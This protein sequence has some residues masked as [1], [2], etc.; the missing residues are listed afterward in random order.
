MKK[1]QLLLLF[2]FFFCTIFGQNTQTPRVL[3]LIPDNCYQLQLI[4][5][6]ELSNDLDLAALDNDKILNPLYKEKKIIKNFVRSWIQM[7]DKSGIDFSTTAAFI[8]NN[9]FLIPLNNEK[10]FEKIARK[11]GEKASFQSI[12][13]NS[14][15]FRLLLD[16]SGSGAILCTDDI[17]C[18]Y[19]NNRIDDD[20]ET[21][22]NELQETVLQ[23]WENMQKSSFLASETGQMF[24]TKGVSSFVAYNAQH[25]DMKMLS[26]FIKKQ[27]TSLSSS[28]D[29]LNI[30]M[31]S[32]YGTEKNRIWS[33]TE[34]YKSTSEG[35]KPSFLTF[36]SP[37]G[38][39]RLLPY[40]L[41]NPIAVISCNV[42]GLGDSLIPFLSSNPDLQAVA[43]LLNHPFIGSLTSDKGYLLC[44]TLDN[45]KAV[46][47]ALEQY[48]ALRNQALDSAF[49]ALQLNDDEEVV[50]EEIVA[51]EDSGDDE[52]VVIEAPY[53]IPAEDSLVNHKHLAHTHTDGYDLYTLTTYKKNLDYE[54]FT[55]VYGY[56]TVC[57]IMTKDNLLFL[58]GEAEIMQSI[59]NPTK[60]SPAGI[61]TQDPLYA[62]VDLNSIINEVAGE[63]GILPLRDMTI[64]TN[65]N[66]IVMDVTATDGLKHNLL[67][68]LVKAIIEQVSS[69]R[70]EI[71]NFKF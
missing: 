60:S 22:P 12:I 26:G 46:Q 21:S 67:Y 2:C 43:P 13:H 61:R 71:K 17:A 20:V 3:K 48:V 62:R 8:N 7:D 25:P 19:L 68:E 41:E 11:M 55:W 38:T 36:L 59:L 28:L 65:D 40:V 24:V 30:F 34:I 31:F 9:C 66:K 18:L 45:P 23:S 33:S 14:Q 29:R 57:F 10:N 15:T 54:T 1:I 4:N 39:Q 32:K 47:P 50:V 16:A 6:S 37:E 51:D 42:V 64:Q 44:T 49:K 56:D 58:F 52:E 35:L 5:W 70:K 53:R 69:I 27:N 63:E